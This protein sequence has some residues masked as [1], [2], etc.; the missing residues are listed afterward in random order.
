[1]FNG[2]LFTLHI[3]S[4]DGNT[5]S[6]SIAFSYTEKAEAGRNWLISVVVPRKCTDSMHQSPTTVQPQSK[7]MKEKRF[8]ITML[9]A[10]H[11]KM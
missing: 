10:Q 4:D 9:A 7:E 8:T 1:M 11:L 3:L 6:I 5:Q 2:V